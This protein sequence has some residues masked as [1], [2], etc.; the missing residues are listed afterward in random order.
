MTGTL[1][2]P[3]L[4]LPDQT[5]QDV[6]RE[7]RY[8]LDGAPR[9][10]SCLLTGS[11]A[12]ALGNER[13]DI[14]VYLVLPDA[15]RPKGQSTSIGMRGN[16]YVDCEYM[17]VGGLSNLADRA[18]SAA[19]LESPLS[20]KEVD[21]FYRIAIACRYLVHPTMA[22]LL[23][24]FE[25]SL[26]CQ[27]SARHFARLATVDA[28]RSALLLA[29]GD[30]RGAALRMRSA[31]L[32]RTTS[33]LAAEGEGY[34]PTKWAFEKA[35]RHWGRDSPRFESLVRSAGCGPDDVLTVWET[36]EPL[37]AGTIEAQGRHVLGKRWRLEPGVQRLGGSS[38]TLVRGRS[39]MRHVEAPAV[40]L[41]DRLAAGESW[42]EARHHA[43]SRLGLAEHV[44]QIGVQ[45]LFEAMHADGYASP[46]GSEPDG[47]EPDGSD[48][49]GR[50][51]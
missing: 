28:C 11:L 39:S 13:S 5:Q 15:D 48:E 38:E 26:A 45:H 29:T 51:C 18:E 1:T 20:T 19:S 37:V 32:S 50:T 42:V 23:G 14:D 34:P 30:P 33:E 21:R 25:R 49:E 8:L 7:V 24:R 17:A 40:E 46:D 22:D 35:A 31:A 12:E 47:S 44:V 3:L 16:R 6:L 9:D 10:A 43:A 36:F 4:D 41:C 27:V 2:G